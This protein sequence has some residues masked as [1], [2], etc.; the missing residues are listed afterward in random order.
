MTAE[1]TA[2]T[3]AP[4]LSRAKV[5][6]ALLRYR[7]LAWIT[8]VCLLALCTHLIV[9]YGFHGHLPNWIPV[10]HGWVYVVY[11]LLTFDLAVKARWLGTRDGQIRTVLTL[12]AGM[13]PFLS[14]YLEHRNAEELKSRLV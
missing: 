8:G 9:N 4:T 3:S 13:I 14:F 10:L 1:T 6:P 2:T 5:G 11:V 7:V 12:L